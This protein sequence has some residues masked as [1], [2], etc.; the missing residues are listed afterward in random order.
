[1]QFQ[2]P[3]FIEIEDKIFGPFTFKQFVYM[4][5]GLASLYIPWHFFGMYVGLLVGG[6]L[7]IFAAALA[8]AK[9]NSRPFI[10]A[11]ESAVRY[12]FSSKLY[13]W[14]HKDKVVQTKMTEEKSARAM[15]VPTL[16]Q[17]KLK[18][19]AWALDV[20]NIKTPQPFN[21]GNT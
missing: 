10:F 1:M 11:A 16:S 3:Q 13:L 20:R 21:S 19:I 8:F 4:L 12:F 9:V 18:D 6:P 14:K 15:A 5:G 17:D 7:A 2:V